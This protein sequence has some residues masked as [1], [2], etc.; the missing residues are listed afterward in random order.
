MSA[1]VTPL[2]V[3]KNIPLLQGKYT[4]VGEIQLDSSMYSQV[5]KI[6]ISLLSTYPLAGLRVMGQVAE[7]DPMILAEKHSPSSAENLTLKSNLPDLD[8]MWLEI[9]PQAA[10]E[11]LDKIQVKVP[12][13]SL[14][15]KKV[16]LSQGAGNPTF[17]IAHELRNYGMDG[18]NSYRIPGLVTTPKGTLLAVYDIRHNSSVDMQGDIDVGLSRSTDQGKTWSKMSTII[19]MGTYGGLPED[20]NGVGDPAVLVDPETGHIWVIALWAHGKPG[21]MIWNSSRPGLT[22]AETG[23]LVLVKSEDDGLTWS[24][25][26][27]ITS[28]MKEPKWNLFFNGPG[29]GIVMEDG[30]LVFPAQYKDEEGMPYSTIISST[31]KG[32]TWKVGTGAKSNTT[33]A[34]VVELSDHSLMLNMRDNRGGSRSVS[35]SNDLGQTWTEH[36]SSR[37][38]LIEP[39]CMASIIT[40]PSKDLLLFSNPAATDGRYNMTIKISE[41]EGKSW[42]DTNQVLLDQ[43]QGWG[44]SCLTMVDEELV[45]ILYESSVANMTFQLVKLEDLIGK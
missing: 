26:V 31:D 21:E 41:D 25:P 28:Q 32:K 37:S 29:K 7:S 19:D 18:V 35:V 40:H 23:Q 27:N 9:Q 6:Q 22:P 44:Y 12:E 43:G 15:K 20:Q 42:S 39:V 45:G 11:L 10:H 4:K 3:S 16:V 17:R 33:E 1:E 13:L 5:T 24:E 30:T 14:G 36:S 2:F 34:Q 38:A 8:K